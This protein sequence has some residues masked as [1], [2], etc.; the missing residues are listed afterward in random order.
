MREASISH[1]DKYIASICD[2][3]R[4]ALW[5]AQAQSMAEVCQQKQY[6]ERKIDMVS[7]KSG[8]LILVM[9]DAFKGGRKI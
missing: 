1:V 3:L 7:L 2:R 5:E 4:T 9:A 8:D 6:Y